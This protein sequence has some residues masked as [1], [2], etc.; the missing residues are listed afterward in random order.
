M[1]A[2]TQRGCIIEM[3]CVMRETTFDVCA[4]VYSIAKHKFVS[5][6]V[7]HDRI[8]YALFPGQYVVMIRSWHVEE[9]NERFRRARRLTTALIRI[10]QSCRIVPLRWRNIETHRFNAVWTALARWYEHNP[11]PPPL[12]DFYRHVPQKVIKLL[13]RT[14]GELETKWLLAYIEHGDLRRL[15]KEVYLAPP[16]CKPFEPCTR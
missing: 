15:F 3:P 8:V 16:G 13:G 6:R 9:E 1:A 10:T 5:G 11:L 2:Q 7:G 14:Y 12:R 4:V